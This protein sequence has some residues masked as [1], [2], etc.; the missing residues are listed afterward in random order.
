VISR[1]LRL[2]PFHSRPEIALP[3]CLATLSMGCAH[4]N[5]PPVRD[6]SYGYI[7]LGPGAL[8]T[9]GIPAGDT[10]PELKL[11]EVPYLVTVAAAREAESLGC[12]LMCTRYF[13]RS[14]NYV[15]LLV[16]ACRPDDSSEDGR[17]M[18]DEYT[19]LWPSRRSRPQ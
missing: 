12:D 17:G 13:R 9:F 5:R 8:R 10:L 3:L 15:V 6:L 4:W 19:R 14:A 7:V 1:Y 11:A 16:G 18:A 2:R